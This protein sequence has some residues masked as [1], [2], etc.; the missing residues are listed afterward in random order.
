MAHMSPTLKRWLGRTGIFFTVAPEFFRYEFP[1]LE[2]TV[3]GIVH[4]ATFAVVSHVRRY[5]GEWIIAP[6]A[7]LDSE[8]LDVILFSGRSRWRFFWLVSPS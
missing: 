1:R 2:V 8:D 4:E 7:S 5:A 3:D 6:D